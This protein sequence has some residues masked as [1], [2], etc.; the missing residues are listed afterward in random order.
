MISPAP[1]MRVAVAGLGFGRKVIVPALRA[2]AST[3]V[4]ALWHPDPQKAAAAAQA[5]EVQ[6]FS[7]FS[8]L[9]DSDHVDAVVIATPPMVRADLARQ[10]LAAGKPVFLEKPVALSADEARQLRMQALQG[11][12]ICGVDFEYRAV[13]LFQQLARLV[14][15]GVLGQPWLVKLDWLMSSR[16]DPARPWSWYARREQGGGVVGALGVHAFDLL[17]WLFGPVASVQARLS[18]AVTARPDPASGWLR[19]CDAEDVAL[20]QLTF[21]RGVVA[22]VNLS[23]VTRNGRGM[24]LELYG[25]HAQV[26]LGSSNQKDYVHGFTMRVARRG[27][28]LEQQEEESAHG[29][30]R[31]WPDGRIAPVARLLDWWAAAVGEGRPMIPGLAEG[32][33]SQMVADAVQKASA[34]AMAVEIP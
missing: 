7:E 10:A 14:Q 23:S 9:L 2:T 30:A 31:T 27:G 19:N 24:W 12:L 26:V 1:P 29:F 5:E 33:A 11:E 22:Q 15:Q 3:V 25:S 20:I 28:A 8:T 34:T 17:T 18:T 32:L 16:A 6:G 4:T 21:A 13:P